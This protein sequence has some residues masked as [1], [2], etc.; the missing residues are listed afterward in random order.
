MFV[1]FPMMLAIC[2]WETSICLWTWT[3]KSSGQNNDGKKLCPCLKLNLIF[4]EVQKSN[5]K[6]LCFTCLFWG[7][8]NFMGSYLHIPVFWSR[9][10]EINKQ[11]N[12]RLVFNISVQVQSNKLERKSMF[13][14]YF[15][16]HFYLILLCSFS[17]LEGTAA[18]GTGLLKFLSKMCLD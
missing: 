18:L 4:L 2:A 16:H 6:L 8:V 17:L 7:Y 5:A 1:I 13:L 11:T 14:W 9:N 12:K 15:K 10:I 3:S